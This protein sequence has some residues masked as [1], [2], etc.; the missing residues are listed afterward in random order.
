MLVEQTKI[1]REETTV[2]SPPY[3]IHSRLEITTLPRN[4]A[5]HVYRTRRPSTRGGSGVETRLSCTVQNC[6]SA[7]SWIKVAF[8]FSSSIWTL[9]VGEDTSFH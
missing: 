8:F 6:D 3:M 9:V 4:T 2:R 5:V 7:C 1:S